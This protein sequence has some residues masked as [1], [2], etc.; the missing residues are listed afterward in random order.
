MCDIMEET[1][2]VTVCSG[3]IGNLINTQR[4]V[5]EACITEADQSAFII[6]KL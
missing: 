4:E 2:S 3:N 6:K 5:L 1:S